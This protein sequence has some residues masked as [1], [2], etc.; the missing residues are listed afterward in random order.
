MLLLRNVLRGVSLED[1]RV[2]LRKITRRRYRG[3]PSGTRELSRKSHVSK[4]MIF[5]ASVSPLGQSCRLRELEVEH[6]WVRY[7]LSEVQVNVSVPIC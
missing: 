2:A 7:L 1:S 4:A 5:A 6:F 3:K